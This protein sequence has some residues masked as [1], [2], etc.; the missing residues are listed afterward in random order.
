MNKISSITLY[1]LIAF[2]LVLSGCGGDDADNGNDKESQ[3]QGT[4]ENGDDNEEDAAEDE[5][6]GDK[7]E[8]KD[9]EEL[10]VGDSADLEG[11]KVTLNEVRVEPGGEFDEPENDQ[12]V[13]VNLT[14]ENNS[15]EEIVV[16]S[17]MNVELYDEEG[18]SYTTTILT[19][20]IQGQFDG[21]VAPDKKLRGEIPFDVPE[22]GE[23][24]LHFSDPF[25]SGRAVWII[26]S[27]DLGK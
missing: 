21:T 14:A 4:E 20:G 3:D 10:S 26:T 8:D 13:V 12:F 7:Q 11:L 1:L 23:Y 9:T 19:E 15:D 27:E 2:I 24:E 25:D 16:S 6:N 22:S 17:I 5:K 18:Y